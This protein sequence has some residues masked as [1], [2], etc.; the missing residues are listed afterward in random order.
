MIKKGP[1]LTKYPKIGKV[2]KLVRTS[3]IIKMVYTE[4]DSRSFFFSYLLT[5][6]I[7]TLS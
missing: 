7:D 5:L 6:R 4:V 3:F 2:I 1:Y